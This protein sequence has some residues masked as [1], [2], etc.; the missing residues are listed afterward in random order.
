MAGAAL[1]LLC[2]AV[3]LG[4]CAHADGVDASAATAA[5]VDP[6]VEPLPPSPKRRMRDPRGVPVFDAGGASAAPET[7]SDASV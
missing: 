1:V 2:S 5:K 3:C 4:A 6:E 7:T